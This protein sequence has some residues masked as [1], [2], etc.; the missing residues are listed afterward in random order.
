MGTPLAPVL[1][2]FLMGHHEKLWL[3]NYAGRKVLYYRR[4][5]DDII[6]CLR[7]SND[8]CLFLSTLTRAIPTL[9]SLWKQK[10]GVS[11]HFRCI[12]I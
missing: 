5:V 3:N 11:C 2:N 9:S 7:N 1:A 8:A 10:K 6:C 4:Y 12:V